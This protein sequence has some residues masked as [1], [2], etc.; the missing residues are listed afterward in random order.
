MVPTPPAIPPVRMLVS[1]GRPIVSN[2]LLV[3]AALTLAFQLKPR[4][5]P[6]ISRPSI[7]NSMPRLRTLPMFVRTL[8]DSAVPAAVGTLNSRS[9][10]VLV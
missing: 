10:V 9:F 8:F 6:S 7:A 3:R 4:G 1:P 2:S 5:P